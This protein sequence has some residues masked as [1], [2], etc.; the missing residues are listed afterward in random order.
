VQRNGS[1]VT[2]PPRSGRKER[3]WRSRL[4]LRV[5]VVLLYSEDIHFCYIAANPLFRR[6]FV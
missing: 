5:T 1:Q 6:L 2:R 3:R 4:A